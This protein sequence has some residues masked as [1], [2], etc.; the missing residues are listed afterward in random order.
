MLGIVGYGSIYCPHSRGKFIAPGRIITMEYFGKTVS[1]QDVHRIRLEGG[2]L[3][4]HV[5]TLG[6]IL[7]DLRLTGFEH[8]LVLGF[9]ELSAYLDHARYFGANVGRVANRI[10]QGRASIAGHDYQLDQNFLGKHML[11]GGMSGAGTQIWKVAEQGSDFVTLS[12]RLPD[13]QMGFPGNLD[14][15]LTYSLIDDGVLELNFT[16]HTDAPTLCNF[17]HHSYFNLDGSASVLEHQLFVDAEAYLPVDA[18]MIPTGEIVPVA[19]TAFDFRQMRRIARTGVDDVHYD[20]N[21]CLSAH[22]QACR[23]VACLQ[24]AE[25]DLTLTLETTEP[26]LQVYDGQWIDV[27]AKYPGLMGVPYAAHAGVALEA[28]GWPD[29]PNHAGFPAIKLQPGEEYQQLTR[30]V[31]G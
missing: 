9:P 7:Q 13:G 5:L 14:V 1:G 11:H 27:P 6:G 20:H 18:E 15:L 25:H 21:F 16:A 19:G 28:Q 3:T 8:P 4:A 17:A 26:G 23:P 22:R 2:G 12:L 29:A 10:A 30:F 31:F 24:G